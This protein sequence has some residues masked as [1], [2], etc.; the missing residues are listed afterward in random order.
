MIWSLPS[1]GDPQVVDHPTAR[2]ILGLSFA[3]E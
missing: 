2:D 3:R 1:R